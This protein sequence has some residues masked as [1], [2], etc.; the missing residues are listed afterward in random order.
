VAASAFIGDGA[1]IMDFAF[2]GEDARIGR[3]TAVFPGVYVGAGSSVGEDC[4]I[5]P[6]AVVRERCIVGNR[7]IIHPGVV[8][9][10]DGFG[11]TTDGDGHHK[12]PQIGRAIL[13][14]DVE[15][16]SNSTID[17]G[18]V[19]DTVICRGAKIDNL[20]MIGHNVRVGENSILVAQTGVSGSTKIGSWTMLGGQ[21]GITGHLEIGSGV[22]I[23]AQSGIMHDVE[24]GAV[25]GGSPAVDKTKWMRQI[26]L[27]HRLEELFRDVRDLK[28]RAGGGEEGSGERKG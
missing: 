28:K 18:T 14:D 11:Y 7:C 24:D 9:G 3:G 8:I 6:N 17:R 20:V 10:A 23:A 2:V 15:I 27:T 1:T 21:A 25:I 5:Y 26:A 22:R 19:G 13:E 12:V 4:T 16:G